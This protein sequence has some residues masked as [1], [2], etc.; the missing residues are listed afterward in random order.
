MIK[1]KLKEECKCIP[2]MGIVALILSAV[3]I[4]SLVLGLKTQWF[5]AVVHTNWTAMAY[6]FIGIFLTALAGISKSH[7]YCR[8]YTSKN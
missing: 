5:S 1:T 4:Y 7:S 3:G 6:Y 2:G 8:H